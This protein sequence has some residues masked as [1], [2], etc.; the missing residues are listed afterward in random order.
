MSLPSDLCA[1]PSAWMCVLSLLQGVRLGAQ[2]PGPWRLP[3][4]SLSS[5]QPACPCGCLSGVHHRVCHPPA[6]PGDC[7]GD[8]CPCL[9][10][11]AGSAGVGRLLCTPQLSSQTSWT[12]GRRLGLLT[13]ASSQEGSARGSGLAFSLTFFIDF[14]GLSFRE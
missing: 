4:H 8:P 9:E 1:Q 10:S 11:R 7:G 14:L 6:E 3:V 12:V 5:C 2:P 13:R